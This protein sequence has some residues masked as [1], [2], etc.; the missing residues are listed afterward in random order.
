VPVR[1]HRHGPGRIDGVPATEQ[2]HGNIF[3]GRVRPDLFTQLVAAEPRHAHVGEDDVR[4]VCSR[5]LQCRLAVVR[6][7]ERDVLVRERHA[8]RLLDRL[9]VIGQKQILGHTRAASKAA[10]RLQ[11]HRHRGK[12]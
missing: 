9:G 4:L 8:D 6:R 5:L 1:A 3:Q 12:F 10:S 2:Q 7:G 11:G